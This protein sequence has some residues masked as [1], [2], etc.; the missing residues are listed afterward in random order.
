MRS[1][2]VITSGRVQGVGYRWFVR[3]EASARGVDGWVRNRRDGTVE[4]ELHGAGADV[5]AVLDSMAQ[6][7]SGA[8]IDDVRVTDVPASASPGFEIRATA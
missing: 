1:V 2:R 3:E 7:P 6:G 8:R 5:Q 4:A